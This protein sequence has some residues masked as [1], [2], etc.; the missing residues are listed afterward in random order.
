MRQKTSVCHSSKHPLA[1]FVETPLARALAA[2]AAQAA[3]RVDLQKQD[4]AA[5]NSQYAQASVAIGV[6]QPANLRH[7]ELLSLGADSALTIVKARDIE[8]GARTTRYQQDDRGHPGYGEPIV[9]SEQA[10]APVPATC[11]RTSARTRAGG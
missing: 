9:R 8:A 10:Q 7:A 5:L 6:S 2:A 11:G 1:V 4:V 3:T